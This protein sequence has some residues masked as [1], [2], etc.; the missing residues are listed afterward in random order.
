MIFLSYT[1]IKDKAIQIWKWYLPTAPAQS[2]AA[3]QARGNDNFWG[4]VCWFL[5]LKV[6]KIE[7]QRDTG[8]T[9]QAS[10]FPQPGNLN[11]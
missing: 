1:C 5:P 7:G 6:R 10:L 11:R 3:L 8:P 2:A 9:T 4:L